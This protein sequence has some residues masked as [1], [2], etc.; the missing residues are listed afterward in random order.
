MKRFSDFAS[1]D[2]ILT[3]DKMKLN[4]ILGKELIVKGYKVADS[5][6]KRGNGADRVLTLQFELGGVDHITFTG[7]NV[8]IDQVEKYKDEMPFVS[9]IEKVNNFYS[10]S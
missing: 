5:K 2:A 6:Y 8:L 9:K 4:D 3:G 7:S 10:F 1:D